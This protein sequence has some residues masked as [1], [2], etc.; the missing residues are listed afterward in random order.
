MKIFNLE[1]CTINTPLPFSTFFQGIEM[2]HR[3]EIE[4]HFT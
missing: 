4:N 3:K 2:R 1:Y